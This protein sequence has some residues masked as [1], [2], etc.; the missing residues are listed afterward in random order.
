MLP[1]PVKEEAMKHGFPV[2][3]PVKVRNPEFLQVLEKDVY[4]RQA[5]AFPFLNKGN[6]CFDFG[7]HGTGSKLVLFDVFLSVCYSDAAKLLLIYLTEVQT[8]VL[9]TCENQKRCV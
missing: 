6:T 5:P 4:K 9:Y 2:Y 1:T 7:K 3:Q 8:Y